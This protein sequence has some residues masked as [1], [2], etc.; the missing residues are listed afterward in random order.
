MHHAF[1]STPERIHAVVACFFRNFDN[2]FI[3]RGEKFACFFN[4]DIFKV[5]RKA[6]ACRFLKTWWEVSF[7]NVKLSCGTCE[8]KIRVAEIVRHV[9]FNFVNRKFFSQNSV[10]IQC[11]AYL[12][13]CLCKK[14][15]ILFLIVLQ[16]WH[17]LTEF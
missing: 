17:I 12:A 3:G 16:F 7:R 4:A 2:G 8:I 5:V 10:R 15:K 6:Y 13:A 14:G 11:K 1:E 9:N